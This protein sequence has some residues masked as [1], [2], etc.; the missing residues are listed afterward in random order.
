MKYIYKQTGVILILCI[1]AA[2]GKSQEP[3]SFHRNFIGISVTELFFSDFRLNYERRLTPSHGIKVELAYKPVRKNFTD[4]TNIDLGQDA[5]GWCYRNTDRCYYAAI[6]YRY[7]FNP[8]K[9]IYISPEMFYKN[10]SADKVVYSYGLGGDGAMLT[11]VYEIR[12]MNANIGGFN[13]LI[14]KRMRI[15]FSESFHM[16]FDAFTGL[17][18]RFKDIHTTIYGST[19]ITH[20]HDEA[21]IPWPVPITDNPLETK[22]N[23]TQVF[24]QLGICFFTSWK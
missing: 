20:Y 12:S 1:L 13:L 15:K 7:Y 4:A 23:Q 19:T 24:A 2:T 6:G 5:T 3:Q 21:P 14:G 9:T 16:G 11:N 8:N 17:S 22:T 18:M 10:M